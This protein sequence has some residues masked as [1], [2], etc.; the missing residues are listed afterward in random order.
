MRGPS[1]EHGIISLSFQHLFE[2]ISSM[3][4][5]TQYRI[6]FSAFQIYKEH[7]FDLLQ[8]ERSDRHVSP[9]ITESPQHGIYVKDL[10]SHPVA[11]YQG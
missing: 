3:A 2:S 5:E 4:T 10:I 9:Q 7:L 6:R 11:S 1:E 8:S